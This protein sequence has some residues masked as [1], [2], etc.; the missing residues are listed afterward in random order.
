MKTALIADDNENVRAALRTLFDR[1]TD[2]TVVAEAA[3]G[4]E[5][6]RKAEELKPDLILMD[7]IMPNM[8][9]AGAA[10]VIKR[11]LPKTQVIL[12]S[13]YSDMVGKHLARTLGVDLVVD[14]S[15][16]AA[17]LTEALGPILSQ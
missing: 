13:L 6:I 5:A 3:D 15:K 10:A 7:L 14:K 11:A 12:F 2:I 4:S 1:R 16:G 9:G 8:S 17:G